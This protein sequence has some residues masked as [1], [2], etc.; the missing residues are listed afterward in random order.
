MT[1][2]FM[3]QLR[4]HLLA[5]VG[6]TNDDPGSVSK[7]YPEDRPIA[8]AAL[9]HKFM[10]AKVPELWQVAKYGSVSW[11]CEPDS[12]GMCQNERLERI[13]S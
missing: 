11:T 8:L 12:A 7:P 5:K 4:V 2:A 6:V 3:C 13:C 10:G 1:P 9:G